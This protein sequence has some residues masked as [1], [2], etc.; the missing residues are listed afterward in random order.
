MP[1]GKLRWEVQCLEEV[2]IVFQM[3][4]AVYA[5]ERFSPGGC[6]LANDSGG[7]VFVEVLRLS[8]I[9]TA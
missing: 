9:Q 5:E 2:A 6:Q 8:G 4:V 7:R 1:P 3:T